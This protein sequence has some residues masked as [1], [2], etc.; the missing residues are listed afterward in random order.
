MGR[1]QLI[2][3][4]DFERASA[5]LLA[6][7]VV[8]VP[9]DTVYGLG[10]ALEVTGT[11]MA[12]FSK[13]QRPSSVAVPV[14][15]ADLSCALALCDE[16]AR[17]ALRRVGEAFW[18]GALTLV[19]ARDVSCT[20]DLGGDRSTIGLRVP[21][22]GGLRELCRSVGPLG[23]TSANVHGGPPCTTP[24][25]LI[26]VFGSELVVLDGGECAGAVSSVIDL[27]GESPVALREGAV[28]LEMVLLALA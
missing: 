14:M 4:D 8:A 3:E 2:G 5:H 7:E 24:A 22:L 26:E 21:A 18:P 19:V 15:V 9:T 20:F 17:G 23:V 25:Q 10:V 12:L 13:K 11:A 6:G 1:R 27:T 28:S 16:T